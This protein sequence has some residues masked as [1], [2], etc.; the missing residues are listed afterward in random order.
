VAAVA[1]V[2]L[3]RAAEPEPESVASAAPEATQR[4]GAAVGSEPQR[5]AGAATR[6]LS[7]DIVER[8]LAGGRKPSD[9]QW[10]VARD[11]QALYT[12]WSDPRF[13]GLFARPSPETGAK[14]AERVE[15][16]RQRLGECQPGQPASVADAEHA[17]FIYTCERGQLEATFTLDA[18][19]LKI[20]G[21][22]I[23]ARDTE[24]EPAVLAAAQ[25]VVALERA[26][27]LELFRRTFGERHEPEK[28]RTFLA[29]V[30]ANRGPCRLGEA[31][32]VSARGGLFAL[33]CEQAERLLKV[34]LDDDDRVGSY[35]ITAPPG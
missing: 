12:E 6:Q 18:R 24:P 21:V 13:E 9:T 34:E 7:P 14:L 5:A 22:A 3:L 25:G 8:L 1:A 17:R 27:D 31:D 11:F 26:W 28:V 2:W 20:D 23:G 16:F 32:R 29:G 15:W 4:P 19:T 30:L 33:H 10:Q 35:A